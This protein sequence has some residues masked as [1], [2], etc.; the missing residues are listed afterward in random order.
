M[1]LYVPERQTDK[2]E[3]ARRDRQTQRQGHLWSQRQ[4]WILATQGWMGPAF[5]EGT[6]SPRAPRT[7]KGKPHPE[8]LVKLTDNQLYT[9]PLAGTRPR[10]KTEEEDLALEAELLADEKELAEHNMLV[11]LGRND[12]GKIS[13]F[14]SVEVEKLRSIERYSHV[15]HIGS[16]VRGKIDSKHDALDA[17]EAVLPAGTLSGAPKIRACQLI[18]EL[19]NNKRGIYGGAIGYIDFTG[20]MDTCIAIRIAYKKNGKVFVRSGAGIVADSNPEKEYEEC[21][22]KAKAVLNSL[23]LAQEV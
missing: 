11:D 12:L 5:W 22:N 23:T 7:P 19:E 9:F 1:I 4:A 16:T 15:M 8:T 14:G 20:N 3:G 2:M 13:E 17:I 6:A 21:L 10:G 18:G